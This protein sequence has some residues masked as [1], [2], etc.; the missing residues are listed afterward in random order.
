MS[1]PVLLKTLAHG[2]SIWLDYI[3]RDL[4]DSGQLNVLVAEGLR[5]M[6]SNPT[7]FEKAISGSADYDPEIRAGEAAGHSPEQI[8]ESLAVADIRRA[9]DALRGVYDL[10]G[11][12][13]GLVSLEVSPKLAHD[14]DRTITA[15]RR[16]WQTVDRPNLMIKVPG[17]AAGLPAIRTLLAAGINVNV[18]LIFSLD[19]YRQIL[20][21]YMR[22]LED[23]SSAGG[24]LASIASVASFFISRV[25]SAADKEL[26]AKG[27]ADLAGKAAIANAGLAYE[28][29][30]AVTETSRWKTLAAKGAHVQR[31]LWAST[32]VKNPAYSDILYV[33][34]LLA[35]DTVNTVPPETLDAWKDHGN[36]RLR[37]PENLKT[38]GAIVAAVNAAGVNLD[39]ITAE[40]LDDGVGKF[41]ASYDTLLAAIAAKLQAKTRP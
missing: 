32:S 17:T 30:L 38:A 15:A 34:E 12:T 35:R 20:E 39:R 4:I 18:T 26:A 33:D 9:C 25:D 6:T 23:R 40:L 37:L 7:I 36:P 3:S 8:F 27:R 10:S 11:R 41:A 19:Q 13:D 16:L 28:H 22:A 24:E 31:P 21:I 5:G 2:Q 1:H 14:T 29:F